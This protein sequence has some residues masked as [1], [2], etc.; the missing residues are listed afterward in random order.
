MIVQYNGALVLSLTVEGHIA[1]AAYCEDENLAEA[2][3]QTL[4]ITAPDGR[5]LLASRVVAV[6]DTATAID[7]TL[8]GRMSANAVFPPSRSLQ[9]IAP[10]GG[11]VAALTLDGDLLAKGDDRTVLANPG[12]TGPF[13]VDAYVYADPGLAYPSGLI[14]GYALFAPS[15]VDWN[16]GTI[17]LSGVIDEVSDASLSSPEYWAFAEA[18]DAFQASATLTNEIKLVGARSAYLA[19]K[20]NYAWPFDITRV[21]LNGMV[22][23]PK[24]A[25]PFPLIVFAHGNHSPLDNSTPGYQYLCEKLASHGIIAATI[26]VNFLNANLHGENGARA[27][28]Q[29]EHV[30]QFE[31]WNARPGHRLHNKVDTSRVMLAGHSRGGEAVA[32]ASMFNRMTSF[33]PAWRRAPVAIDGTGT[34]PLGPYAFGL[35][36]LIAIAPT[37]DQ[38]KP[39][40]PLLHQGVVSTVIDRTSYL[41]IHGTMDADVVSFDGYRAYDRALPYDLDRMREPATGYKALMWVYQANHN[42]FNTTWGHDSDQDPVKVMDPNL[43]RQLASVVFGAWAQVH[44]LGR[45][46]YWPIVRRPQLARTNAWLSADVTLVSQ[47]HD[48]CR[49]WVHTFD[50]SGLLQVS[51]PVTGVPDTRNCTAEQR[52]LAVSDPG[53]LHRD[54]PTGFL[55]QQTGGLRVLWNTS[56]ERY[57]VSDLDFH[58]DTARLQVLSVRAGQSIEAQNPADTPQDFR[59][60]VT[61][62]AGTTFGAQASAYAALPYP[63]P[64]SDPPDLSEYER[65]TVMQTLRIPLSEIAGAGVNVREIRRIEF[66]F[67]VTAKGVMYFDDLQLS[68]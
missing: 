33:T 1:F 13:P 64:L 21:P 56:G 59:I 8:A 22:W 65:K 25:G 36:G 67:D 35:R 48:R 50:N 12:A 29:L 47:Y 61:D 38:Y 49:L 18:Y 15:T 62:R 2:T 44:L 51:A 66:V 58:G 41:L 60:L 31:G 28:L 39:V 20:A 34:Q 11:V 42:Y 4:S 46:S 40:A 54:D 3:P 6:S 37:D 52:Y 16:T 24:G 68:L 23:V 43:Q 17:D 53:D 5:R 32:H 63:G 14:A 10:G 26:D 27:I 7:V 45:S 30:K 9:I 19:A 57:I 55:Y